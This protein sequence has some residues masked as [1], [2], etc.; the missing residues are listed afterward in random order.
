[1][2]IDR[3]FEDGEKKKKKWGNGDGWMGDP[4]VD[5]SDIYFLSSFLSFFYSFFRGGFCF[6]FSRRKG[7]G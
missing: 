2:E 3:G 1:M 6:S 4:P 7:E 5:R